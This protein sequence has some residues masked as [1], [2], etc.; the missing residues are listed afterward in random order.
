MP[1]GENKKKNEHFVELKKYEQAKMISHVQ[2]GQT[3]AHN[4]GLN[5]QLNEMHN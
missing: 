3:Q 1:K 2:A 5:I 4:K